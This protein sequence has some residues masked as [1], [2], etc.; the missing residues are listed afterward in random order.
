MFLNL[1]SASKCPQDLQGWLA[2]AKALSITSAPSPFHYKPLHLFPESLQLEVMGVPLNLSSLALNVTLSGNAASGA[3]NPVKLGVNA[4][5]TDGYAF[6]DTILTGGPQLQRFVGVPPSVSS[7]NANLA[8]IK[9][10]S[11][12]S[13][14]I[15]LSNFNVSF[16]GKTSGV[17]G[18]KPWTGSL[19]FSF[20]GPLTMTGMLGCP[21]DCGD[22]GRCIAA[23]NSSTATNSTSEY[24]C[25]CQCGWAA[26][27]ATGRCEVP[28]GTCP[29]YTGDSTTGAALTAT[30]AAESCPGGDASA[31]MAANGVCPNSYG[32]DVMSKACQKCD[33]D[34]T[35]TG[36]KQCTTDSACRVSGLSMHW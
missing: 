11:T 30:R 7:S 2:A 14:S 27:P 8:I 28:A 5:I 10:G 22:F 4:T 18:G 17:M 13:L 1:P 9:Q 35:G 15:T 20:S 3:A 24:S 19:I 36:C 26:D 31:V 6:S 12:N 32:Y 23:N 34:W 25:E 21:K 29:I 16:V 33:T